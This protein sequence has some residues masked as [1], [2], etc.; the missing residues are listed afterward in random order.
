MRFFQKAF[1]GYAQ[2]ESNKD[3]IDIDECRDENDQTKLSEKIFKDQ[4][5][6]CTKLSQVR[7]EALPSKSLFLVLCE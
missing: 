4:G 3:C 1:Q 2:G 6:K 7:F 5:G